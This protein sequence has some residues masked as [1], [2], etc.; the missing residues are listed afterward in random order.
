M[1][2]VPVAALPEVVAVRARARRDATPTPSSARRSGWREWRATSRPR[3]S[4]RPAS[5]PASARTPT[6]PGS[7]VLLN[8]GPHPPPERDGLLTTVAWGIGGRIDY[9]LEASVFVTGAAVQWLRDGLGIIRGRRRDR[10]ARRIARLQRRRLLR[11]GPDRARLAPLGP[12]RARDDRGPDARH[13]SRASRARGARGDRLPDGRCGRGDGGGLGQAARRA[14][15]RRRRGR[16]RVADAV[17]GRRARAGPSSCPEIA[18]TT[19][20]GAAYLAGVDGTWTSRTWAACGR[21][22]PAT[23][24]G[25]ARTSGSRC[26]TAGGG[27]SKARGNGPSGVT[28]PVRP[29]VAE[30]SMKPQ[31]Y[32]DPR[33]AELFDKY[34]ERVRRGRPGLGLPA[35]ADRPD[36]DRSCSSTGTARSAR[37]T[38]PSAGRDPGAEPLQ[39]LRPLLPRRAAA[40]RG[41]VHGQVAALQAALIDFIITHG[42]TFPVRRGHH[43]EEAFITAHTILER[44]GVVLMYAE[45]GRSRT[46]S[47]ASQARARPAGARVGRAGGAG[48]DPRLAARARGERLLFPKVTVQFGEPINFAQVEPDREQSQGARSRSSSTCARCTRRFT[49]R[50]A[51]G[52]LRAFAASAAQALPAT[53]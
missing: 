25:W 46:S 27:R 36:A 14:A 42:G 43:D 35:R 41:A 8:T 15:G 51:E 26:C 22:R 11:A 45:G 2:G 40:P 37:R 3:S 24:R 48:R 34:H 30:A 1:L 18:E 23:S 6:G 39:L 9:A 33:P 5:S 38:C 47:S 12:V 17:P 20:L 52:V 4:A 16:Q 28:A 50:D 44:G 49:P 32:I 19:A 10:G 53:G 29:G 21:R 31:V 13:R 7:F